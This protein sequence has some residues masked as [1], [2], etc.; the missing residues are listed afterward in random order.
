MLHKTVR[1]CTCEAVTAGLLRHRLRTSVDPI[2]QWSTYTCLDLADTKSTGRGARSRRQ[3]KQ[4]KMKE[5]GT[6][7]AQLSYSYPQSYHYKVHV[8]PHCASSIN[9]NTVSH[10]MSDPVSDSTGQESVWLKCYH[11]CRDYQT[12]L[13]P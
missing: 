8:V 3:D 5:T 4:P 1:T 11:G 10:S 6:E 13:R 2:V 12:S 9:D 7:T